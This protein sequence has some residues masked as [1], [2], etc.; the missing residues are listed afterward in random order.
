MSILERLENDMKKAAKARDTERLGV[1]RFVRSQTKNLE[2][3]LMRKLADEDVIGVLAKLAKQHRE[4]IEQFTA[5]GRAELVAAE[6]RKLG[7]VTEYLPAPLDESELQDIVSAAIEETGASTP[8]D[9]GL[10]MK[11][12][13]PRVKGRVE[14]DEVKR[15]V[16]SRLTRGE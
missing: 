15:V 6:E 12:V 4:A 16:V 7:I 14:G 8:G 9:M 1:I 13:M 10:V 5:G 11:A 2:I 3:E